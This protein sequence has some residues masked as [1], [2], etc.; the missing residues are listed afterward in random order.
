AEIVGEVGLDVLLEVG[1]R[2]AR[3]GGGRDE[4]EGEEAGAGPSRAAADDEGDEG[5][6]GEDGEGAA[7]GP[8]ARRAPALG[9][10][11]AGLVVLPEVARRLGADDAEIDRPRVPRAV[12]RDQGDAVGDAVVE[13]ADADARGARVR[14]AADE[15]G[16]EP[17]DRVVVGLAAVGEGL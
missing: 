17:G 3:G 12:D 13:P 11:A 6:E 8:A 16:I 4:D 1:L 14:A 9:G 5:D 15:R 10:P 7:A 2:A